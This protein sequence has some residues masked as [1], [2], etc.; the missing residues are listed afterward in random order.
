LLIDIELLMENKIV[1]LK[2]MIECNSFIVLCG[3]DS[4][5]NCSYEGAAR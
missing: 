1:E 2:S 5:L 4:I 3:R